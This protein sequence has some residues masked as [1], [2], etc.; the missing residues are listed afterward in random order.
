MVREIY[1]LFLSGETFW[2][3][4]KMLT[5]RGV[6]TPTGKNKWQTCTIQSILQNEKYKGAAL[7]QKKFTTD[8]LTKKQKVNEGEVPQYYV[9]NSHPAIID[10]R[11]WELTQTELKRRSSNGK[12]NTGCNIFSSRIICAECGSFYNHRSWSTKKKGRQVT[13]HCSR[14][15]YKD[16]SCDS[17][18]SSFPLAKP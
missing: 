2:S 11:L 9:E 8:F 17:P 10:P 13:W 16:R 1:D 5:E 4:A 14:K 18:G 6:P 12:G 7:L 15:Y 3:I